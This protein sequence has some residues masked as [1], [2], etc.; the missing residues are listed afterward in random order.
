VLSNLSKQLSLKKGDYVPAP[1]VPRLL[2]RCGIKLPD[3]EVAS[4][5]KT[6]KVSRD[7]GRRMTN[8]LK[9]ANDGVNWLSTG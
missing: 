9:R 5:V 2:R 3:T 1:D 6:L 7:A 4:I 8:S